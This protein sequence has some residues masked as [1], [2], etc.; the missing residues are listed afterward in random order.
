MPLLAEAIGVGRRDAFDPYRIFRPEALQFGNLS[1]ID[2]VKPEW[3][4]LSDGLNVPRPASEVSSEV[5][6]ALALLDAMKTYDASF[7][8]L[9][10]ALSRPY[11]YLPH[12]ANDLSSFQ[13]RH[14]NFIRDAVRILRLRAGAHL[15][16]K[17]A[18]MAVGDVGAILDCTSL[19]SDTDLIALLVTCTTIAD[20]LRPIWLGM[21]EQEWSA[22]E[23]RALDSELAKLD[24]SSMLLKALRGERAMSMAMIEAFSNDRRLAA[25][26]LTAA[27]H[28]IT[29]GSHPT[30][31]GMGH[32]LLWSAPKGWF[33]RN[34]VQHSQNIQGILRSLSKSKW[35]IPPKL[36][37][38]KWAPYTF[39]A[40]HLVSGLNHLPLAVRHTEAILAQARAAIAIELFRQSSGHLPASL[41]EL[42][43]APPPDPMTGAPLLYQRVDDTRYKLWSVATNGLDD[44]GET[45]PS[46]STARALD[47]VWQSWI[48]QEFEKAG[49]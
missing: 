3:I 43:P 42:S 6:A 29:G 25:T 46:S 5:D 26:H 10:E 38:L 7:Q 20:A 49:D 36:P 37:P 33:K 34:Q 2:G 1:W 4:R 32:L 41:A 12:A 35:G 16:A 17:Q 21:T 22:K 28:P 18:A 13:W 19:S 23:L 15:A 27:Q 11:F 14:Y 9:R 40:T 45:G 8:E 24:L 48:N 47:W 39:M 30:R 31:F 44:G